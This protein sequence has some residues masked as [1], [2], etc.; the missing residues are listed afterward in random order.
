[1]GTES[2]TIRSDL[3]ATEVGEKLRREPFAFD[4]FQAVRLLERFLPERTSVGRFAHPQT[5]VARFGV[6]P[7]LAFP[8]SQIQGLDSPEDGQV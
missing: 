7:S 2:G 3:A 1:M 4:F 6:N 8:A 5:E